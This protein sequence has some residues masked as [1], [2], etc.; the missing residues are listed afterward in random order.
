MKKLIVVIAAAAM[1]AVTMPARAEKTPPPA[2]SLLCKNGKLAKVW[3]T[4]FKVDN[5]CADHDKEWVEVYIQFGDEDVYLWN[6]AGGAKYS[7]KL[8]IDRTENDSTG[9][10]QRVYVS[11]DRGLFCMGDGYAFMDIN[12]IETIYRPGSTWRA[13]CPDN[14]S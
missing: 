12:G 14:Q 5:R 11:L 3:L 6:V 8:K 2:Y 13:T 4:P 1:L 7:N 10:G 9:W